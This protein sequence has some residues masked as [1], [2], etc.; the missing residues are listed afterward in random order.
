MARFLFVVPPLAGHVNPTVA[1]GRALHTEGHDVAWVG[2]PSQVRALIPPDLDLIPVDETQISTLQ[3]MWLQKSQKVFGLD[4][5]KFF[6]Q[7]FMI[8]LAALMY[9][10]VLE[11]LD[12][13]KPDFVISDQQALAGA[14]AARKMGCK[15]ATSVT[16][17]AG[18]IN[19]LE[20]FPKVNQWMTDRL[21]D[22]QSRFALERWERPDISKRLVLVFSAHELVGTHLNFPD[23]YHF[24][25]PS[26]RSETS[27]EPAFPWDQIDDSKPK[28]FLSLG[29]LNAERSTKFYAKVKEAFAGQ[30]LQVIVSAPPEMLGEIPSNF[31]VQKGVPQLSLLKRVDAVVFHGGHNTFCESLSNGLPLV[32]APIKDDQPVIAEQVVRSGTG[33]RVHFDRVTSDALRSATLQVLED[34]KFRESA[35]AIQRIFQLRGGAQSA[36]DLIAQS[37]AQR[38]FVESRKSA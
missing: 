12:A 35:R 31:I 23:H 37:C 14:L 17:S 18:I 32:V 27:R 8:P 2:C 29:T 21:G 26:L 4:S 34:P 38:D 22:L 11:A 33:L 1:V 25:G 9:P 20:Q 24:V 5:Y 15:W 19:P 36:A 16:T 6:F 13:F 30:N 3:Q 10:S 28:V 7:D